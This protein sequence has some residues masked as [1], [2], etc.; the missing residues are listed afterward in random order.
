MLPAGLPGEILAE[1]TVPADALPDGET[2]AMLAL[3]TWQP[4][5]TAEVPAGTFEKGILVDVLVEGSYAMRS[6]GPLLV[7]RD[8]VAASLEEIAAEEETVLAT[9]DAVLYL[10]N[11]AHWVFRNADPAYPGMAIEALIISTDPPAL[12]VESVV[13]PEHVDEDPSLH[14]EVLARTVPATWKDGATGPLTLTIWRA[15][16]EPDAAIAA[17]ADGVVQLIAPENGEA[18]D[19]TVSPD[20]SARNGGQAPDSVVGLTVTS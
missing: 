15:E 12:P 17:P 6:G 14:L 20:G 5:S 13:D 2:A 8:G 18:P 7:A 3:F 11:D 10:E 4:N 19:L 9:G 1:I 16:L